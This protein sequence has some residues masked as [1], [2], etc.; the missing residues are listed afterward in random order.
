MPNRYN[1][2]MTN[3]IRQLRKKHGLSQQALADRL[4]CSSQ[5][6]HRLEV[7][8]RRLT[9][10]W[11]RRIGEALGEEPAVVAGFT[12]P[13]VDPAR[14]R[15]VPLIGEVEAGVWREALEWGEEEEQERFPIPVDP[16]WQGQPLFAL[17]VRGPS[18][19]RLY[20]DGSIIYCVRYADLAR[21][22]KPGERVICRRVNN[23]GLVEATVKELEIDPD[24]NAWLW[25][26]SSHPEHQQPIR[27]PR[28]VAND[29]EALP[30][31]LEARAD[32][33]FFDDGQTESVEIVGRVVG[34]LRLEP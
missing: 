25:P 4:G 13:E 28:V 15:M 23:N 34:S 14:L 27:L 32:G 7:G 5:Q 22:P 18:M 3:R 11:A 19:D 6:I 20:P 29:E 1:A 31:P 9:D 33:S 8:L 24:G 12:T 2:E 26:R 30:D 21:D 17:R 10:Q 16:R